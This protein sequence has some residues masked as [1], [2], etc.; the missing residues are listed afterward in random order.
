MQFLIGLKKSPDECKDFVTG[1]AIFGP[2]DLHNL[3]FNLGTIEFQERPHFGVA[4]T[5]HHEVTL[6]LVHHLWV[7]GYLPF[8]LAPHFGVGEA[9][10][11][12]YSDPTFVGPSLA[13]LG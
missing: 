6:L 5:G 2:L 3:S 7:K 9:N 4:T 1:H 10:W 8:N 13:S 12:H 11:G